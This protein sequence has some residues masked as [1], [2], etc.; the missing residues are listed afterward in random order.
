[1]LA[2]NILIGEVDS[3][4]EKGYCAALYENLRCCAK[5][6]HVHVLNDTDFIAHLLEKA[7]PEF[8]GG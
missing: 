7:E 3:A 2:Y 8:L 4:S 1:M 5:E 6:Q